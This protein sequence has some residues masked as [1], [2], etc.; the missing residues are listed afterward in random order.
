MLTEAIFCLAATIYFEAKGEPDEGMVAVG[1]VVMNRVEQRDKT[2]CQV[3]QEPGQF[4]WVPSYKRKSIKIDRDSLD[5]K[6]AITYSHLILDRSYTF[7]PVGK[8]SYFHSGR[9][10]KTFNGAYHVT[11][12]GG[13]HFYVSPNDTEKTVMN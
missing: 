5:W 8:A 6:K 9:R 2:I 4:V 3:V 1:R 13:H 12:I 11:S 7:N 10:T